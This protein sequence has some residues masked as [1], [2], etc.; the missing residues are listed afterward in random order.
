VRGAGRHEHFFDDNEDLRSSSR[1]GVDWPALV[2]SPSA[3]TGPATASGRT[4]GPRL[5]P[6]GRRQLGSLAAEVVAAR[7]RPRSTARRR[8]WWTAGGGAEATRAIFD[9]LRQAECHRLHP[10]RAGGLNVPLVAYFAP[11]RA[12]GPRRRGHDDHFS[13]HGG[14]AMA[15]LV[16]RS[17]RARRPSTRGRHAPGPASPSRSEI[18]SGAAWVHGHHRARRRQHMASSAREPRQD[19]GGNW[20]VS[21]EKV[22]ITSGHARYHFVIARTEAAQPGRPLRRLGGLRCSCQGLGGRAGAS[23]VTPR[24][25][26]PARGQARH[27]GSVTGRS[28][29]TARQPSASA[30]A[31]RAFATCWC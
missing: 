20:F 3:A 5:L 23:R 21:G 7:A 13:F 27:R 22:F 6:R 16:F 19:A 12:P 17:R 31:A 9:A 26:R 15:A 30:G 2:R 1:R 29:S 8:V 10:S 18:A 11:A 25:H 28:P 14:M 4:G 24:D